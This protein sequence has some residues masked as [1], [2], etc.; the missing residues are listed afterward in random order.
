MKFRKLALLLCICIL[1]LAAACNKPQ[2]TKTEIQEQV[3]ASSLGYSDGAQDKQVALSPDSARAAAFE[4]VAAAYLRNIWSV[5]IMSQYAIPCFADTADLQAKYD[6]LDPTGDTMDR[7]LLGVLDLQETAAEQGVPTRCDIALYGA[8]GNY[9]IP[10]VV[11]SELV[12]DWYGIE[13]DPKKLSGYREQDD[14]LVLALGYMREG[15]IYGAVNARPGEI[16]IARNENLICAKV[17]II[18]VVHLKGWDG[19]MLGWRES[20]AGYIEVA[21]E[22]QGSGYTIRALEDHI[23]WGPWS[24]LEKNA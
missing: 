16:T 14:T 11:F 9:T 24:V 21:L 4:A 7:F 15:G 8:D 13:I 1:Y 23:E 22:E 10:A 19:T 3:L 6:A 20:P 2:P 18:Q 17:V 12:R 5:D